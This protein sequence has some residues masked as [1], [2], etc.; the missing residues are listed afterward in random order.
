MSSNVSPFVFN[1]ARTGG[2]WEANSSEEFLA[3][4]VMCKGPSF[5]SL[6]HPSYIEDV[7]VSEE[8]SKGGVG[9]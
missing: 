7:L 3:D 6:H 1:Q 8:K 2:T 5:F 4:E 9:G